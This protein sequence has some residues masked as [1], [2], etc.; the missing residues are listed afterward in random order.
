MD[1]RAVSFGVTPTLILQPLASRMTHQQHLEAVAEHIGVLRTDVSSF[2]RRIRFVKAKLDVIA[3]QLFRQQCWCTF[4][5]SPMSSLPPELLLRVF[6][7]TQSND[8]YAVRR[9]ARFSWQWRDVAMQERSLW[10]H[11]DTHR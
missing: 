8:L 2:S 11:Q 10:A 4:A 7:F 1:V 9:I 6:A 3:T 5:M